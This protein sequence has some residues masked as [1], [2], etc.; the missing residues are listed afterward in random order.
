MNK[1]KEMTAFISSVGADDGQPLNVSNNS[2]SEKAG[3]INELETI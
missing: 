1:Q 2:I 3:K